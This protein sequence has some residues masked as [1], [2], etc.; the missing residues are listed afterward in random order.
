MACT[1]DADVITSQVL[2]S[3]PIPRRTKRLLLRTKNSGLWDDANGTFV[4]EYATLNR[5]AARWIVDRGIKLLG[6]DYLSVETYGDAGC[7][8]HKTLLAGGVII[9]ESL[10]LSGISPGMY[11]LICLPLK[12]TGAEAAPA[13]AV[14]RVMKGEHN[15]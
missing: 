15:G 2:D 8:I 9:V 3:L 11:E 14:L 10:N 4:R 7:P 6:V 13:R 1:A 5:E 12:L